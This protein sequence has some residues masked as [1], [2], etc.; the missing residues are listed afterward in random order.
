VRNERILVVDDDKTVLKSMKGILESEG[1]SVDTVEE[2]R[3]SLAR[4]ESEFYDLVL[5]DI[6][7]PDIEGTKLLKTLDARFPGTVKIMVTGYPTLT[8]AVES[9]NKGADAY[10]MKPVNPRGL[11]KV[12]KDR[13]AR[14]EKARNIGREDVKQPNKAK[15]KSP[16]PARE[17]KRP[18]SAREEK[19][20][21]DEMIE[22]A[23]LLLK[24]E[25]RQR[26]TVNRPRVKEV[27]V[28][29]N[30]TPVQKPQSPEQNFWFSL[31]NLDVRSTEVSRKA[32][33]R[34]ADAKPR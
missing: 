9:L 7:L 22:R 24:N 2:G 28:K 34:K 12:V 3:L 31:A 26:K 25:K 27:E 23:Q 20:P 29:G 6:K 5:L 30:M 16:E 4:F 18:T 1:Y 21:V 13:L 17:E 33:K 19:N 14:Q 11:L 8:N 10:L 15:D 32:K